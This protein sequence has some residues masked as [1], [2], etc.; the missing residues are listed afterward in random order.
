MMHTVMVNWSFCAGI[1]TMTRHILLFCCVFA[2]VT[3]HIISEDSYY[4]E[5]EPCTYN[6]SASIHED[7]FQS[8]LLRCVILCIQHKD[9]VQLIFNKSGTTGRSG[10]CIMQMNQRAM[11]ISKHQNDPDD[12]TIVS[13]K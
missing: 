4:L 10:L 9:C 3:C 12:V 6:I 5:G 1:I 8:T 2:H 7:A 11:I 13:N